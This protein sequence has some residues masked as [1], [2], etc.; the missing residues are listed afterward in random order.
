MV[1]PIL[2]RSPSGRPGLREISSQ[3]SPPSKLLNRPLPG[4]PLEMFQKL[5]RASHIE[6]NSRRG[7]LGSIVRSIVPA[8]SLR[9]R[10]FCQLLPPSFER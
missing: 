6:A 4:P 1:T 9:C 10:I 2:P 3:V 7:L 8:T 5:R